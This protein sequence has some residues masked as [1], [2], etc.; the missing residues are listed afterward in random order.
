MKPF[1]ILHHRPDEETHQQELKAILQFGN[2]TNQDIVS[3]R[4]DREDIPEI[5]FS[6]YSG[7]IIGGGPWNT[8]LPDDQKS[9]E[10]RKAETSLVPLLHRVLEEDIPLFGICYGME[11]LVV[12]TG[13]KE[14]HERYGESAGAVDI[15]LTKEGKQDL[16][17][18]GLPETFR[19]FVGHKE[20]CDALPSEA[21]W[22][23]TSE[24]CPYQMMRIKNNIYATQFHPELETEGF[25]LR[26]D[27]YKHTG[28]FLPAQFEMIQAA[29]QQEHIT[30][31]L[32]ILRRFVQRYSRE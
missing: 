6:L 19:A 13:G 17:L 27:V 24:K 32:E 23:A 10:Q 31:P 2:L 5:D 18:Q 15:E 21:I 30:V 14:T 25:C 9:S 26:T 11:I 28:Y 4:M 8:Y 29:A 1:L 3:I 22:L 12:C 16:L 20:A 7:I